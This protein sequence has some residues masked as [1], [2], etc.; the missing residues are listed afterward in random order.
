MVSVRIVCVGNLKESYWREAYAEYVK[1]LGR[2]CSFETVETD[3]SA[4]E[5]EK[6]QIIRAL[7]GYVFALCIEGKQCT[8]E[9]FADKIQKVMQTSSRLTF[10][11]GGSD[12]LSEDVK[13]LA[14]SRLSFSEMTFPH[15]LMRV[16]LSEQ[17]YR[18]FTILNHITYH[19]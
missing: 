7:Q 1:R 16:V 8:S 10:I 6:T 18:A 3:E 4:P 13:K 9:E 15:H 2:F 5:K 11:I 17:I 14:D 12:G 19:K